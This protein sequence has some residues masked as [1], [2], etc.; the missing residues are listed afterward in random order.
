MNALTSAIKRAKLWTQPP[1]TAAIQKEV[2]KLLTD[3]T[4][5]NPIATTKLIDYFGS[6]LQFGTG[7][8]RAL[9]GIGT[10][11]IN[12][13]TIARI[14][15]GLALYLHN[16]WDNHLGESTSQ[17]KILGVIA[18]D[19]RLNSDYFAAITAQ[20]LAENDIH[21]YKFNAPRP[22][23]ELSFAVRTY[24]AHFGIVITASHNPKEYSGY[25]VYNEKGA[26]II[27]PAD[28]LITEA[29]H[30]IKS[31]AL[32]LDKYNL[33]TK[34]AERN[35]PAAEGAIS[36]LSE[37]FDNIYLEG[38]LSA[39][40][41]LQNEAAA[42]ELKRK[43]KIF[44]TPLYGTGIT[45]I[46]KGFRRAGFENFHLIEQEC[47]MDGNFPG[48]S[49]PNPEEAS[50][51]T[52]GQETLAAEQGHLLLAT[53]PDNDRVG[54]VVATKLPTQ[55]KPVSFKTLSGNQL[56]VILTHYLLSRLK[57]TKQLAALEKPGFIANTIV[58][59]PLM[60]VIGHRFGIPCYKTFTGFK[61][62]AA[63]IDIYE[64][65][66]TF[67]LGAEESFGY[68]VAPYIRDKDATGSALL[69]AEA[70]IAAA[71]NGKTLV[72]VLTDIYLNYGY[73]HESTFSLTLTGHTGKQKIETLMNFFRTTPLKK[74]LNIP[75]THVHDYLAPPKNDQNT[76]TSSPV[77]YKKGDS[78]KSLYKNAPPLPA[79]ADVLQFT[80]KDQTLITIRPS[81]TEP[82]IKFYFS[83]HA[84]VTHAAELAQ[85]T[86]AIADTV[87]M[88]TAELRNIAEKVW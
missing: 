30:K 5:E 62:I 87:K 74:L 63:L 40:P 73:F 42:K 36:Y 17:K 3:A 1:F 84:N 15:K 71:S 16:T 35:L 12:A 81:G 7:G 37:K 68:L 38:V 19:S 4:T 75:V 57:E 32:S 41:P 54:A 53:D 52:V 69:L 76:I 65:Q 31:Y 56:A 85:T 14:T 82:K 72:D 60:A 43:F 21:I 88:L 44:Y 2:T 80:L 8:M 51:L 79:G 64:D 39:L 83:L 11:R 25:K 66:Q 55:K 34:Q 20:V 24:N 70:A 45:V 86:L 61:H 50:A 10:N 33:T 77:D 13:Y 47:Q 26:Q 48:L 49:A 18:Y 27:A 23:P 9:M 58:T 29:I 46:P 59:T 67:L 6:E 28:R 78:Y 22:T